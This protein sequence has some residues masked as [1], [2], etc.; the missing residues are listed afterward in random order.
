MPYVKK[1]DIKVEDL[2][3]KEVEFL[4]GMVS[5]LQEQNKSLMLQISGLSSAPLENSEA[6]S[7]SPKISD[8]VINHF[9]DIMGHDNDIEITEENEEQGL[10]NTG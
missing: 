2:L 8:S 7:P 4:K 6:N 3:Y 5:F 9:R 1:R 10:G